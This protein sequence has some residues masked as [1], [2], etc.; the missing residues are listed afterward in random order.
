[1]PVP[2]A[3][4]LGPDIE[5]MFRD[6]KAGDESARKEIEELV[7]DECTGRQAREFERQIVAWKS[8]ERR[9]EQTT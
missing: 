1:M 8:A 4:A 6:W 7:L 9:L 2:K 5:G 3:E